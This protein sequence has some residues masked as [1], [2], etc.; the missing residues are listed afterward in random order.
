MKNVTHTGTDCGARKELLLTSRE[1][2]CLIELSG[3]E[4][5]VLP[6]GQRRLRAQVALV[7]LQQRCPM[8]AG[9][10][11]TDRESIHSTC[12]SGWCERLSSADA[13]LTRTLPSAQLEAKHAARSR[14]VQSRARRARGEIVP[15]ARHSNAA[16]RGRVPTQKELVQANVHGS[17]RLGW[18]QKKRLD[19][20]VKS[21]SYSEIGV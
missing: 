21:P 17:T 14:Y 6:S 2:E 20:H 5:L 18:L 9:V 16:R 15:R 11:F 4:L 13:R 1:L 7:L 12:L 8:C 19:R 10:V 3:V